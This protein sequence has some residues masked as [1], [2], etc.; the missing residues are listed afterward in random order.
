MMNKP[1]EIKGSI[2]ARNTL[3]NL[4]GQG[5]PLVV[6]I[7]TMPLI[8]QGLGTERFGLLALAWVVLG[9]F[10]IFDLGLGRAT[11]KFVAEALGKGEEEQ[12]PRL[13][14][15][16][17]T[18]QVF[19]GLLG[20]IVLASI[21]PLLV[22]RILNIPPALIKEAKDTFYLLSLS[23]PVVLVSSSFR[24]VLEAIQRFDLVNIVRVPSS[25][26][27]FLL[28]LV[29]LFLGFNLP[30][31]VSLILAVRLT[32]L[33]V[34]VV[35]S[36]RIAPRL[37]RY[38]SSFALLSRL[39]SFGG[40][41]M[42]SS[43]VG[44]ILV[45]LDR[46]LIASLMSMAALAYYSA[47]Y[48]AVTRLWVISTSLAM[49]LFP[50]FS[51]L[52]GVRDRQK[53]GILFAR[54]VKYILLVIGPIVLIIGL[55]AEDI[56][57]AWLG[58]DFAVKSTV[59]LQVFALGVLIS[60]L[61]WIP[62]VLLQGAGRPDIPAKFHL[63]QLPLYIGIVWFSVNQWGIAGAA[64]AWTCRVALEAVLLF[65][66]SFKVY[67]LAP[68]LLVDNGTILTGF[69]LTVLASTVYGL[70][71]LVGDSSLAAQVLLVSGLFCLFAWFSWMNILDTSDKEMIFKV[72]KLR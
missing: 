20:A 30:G 40:W 21:T 5:L 37:K 31:I 64:W 62:C 1:L 13:V 34:F 29:G 47:P 12:V 10:V 57:Q 41:M 63:L 65:G 16:A 23:I 32:E 17:V 9:Y 25:T 60:S 52:E 3:F 56:L 61:A 18:I 51:S 22:E 8:I 67:R 28:P 55:F 11:T 7:V 53:L 33:T 71:I 69:A 49:T 6:A 45:H 35:M 48:E 36:I 24:G 27:T 72:V 58:A 15:T 68:R 59:V 38:S 19:F 70:K 44:P 46:F 4:I 2:L 43:I 39:F 54:A 14:W 26:L 42:V 50:A 66:A